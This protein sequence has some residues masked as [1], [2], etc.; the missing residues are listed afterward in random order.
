[1]VTS[2]T[3]D[4]DKDGKASRCT[5]HT[6]IKKPD[7]HTHYY[8]STGLFLL[9]DEKRNEV[10]ALQMVASHYCAFSAA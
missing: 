6:H 4:A 3:Y 2:H 8:Y 10:T 5:L 1:M 9:I 7:S